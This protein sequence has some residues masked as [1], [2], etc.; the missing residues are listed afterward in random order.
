MNFES[1]IIYCYL[2]NSFKFYCLFMF[3]FGNVL[4]L[5]GI[6]GIGKSIVFKIFS[7]KFKFNLGRFDNLLDWEDVIKYFCG[8]ELQSM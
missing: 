2:V 7:G 6:N 1:Q 3:R 4:G 5:V 8:F